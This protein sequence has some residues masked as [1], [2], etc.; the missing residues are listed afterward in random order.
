[1]ADVQVEVHLEEADARRALAEQTRAGLT[2]EQKSLP[3]VWFYDERGSQLFDDITRLPD[4]YP[5]RTERQILED[6]APAVV[7]H[8]GTDTLVEL[9]SGTSTKTRL[10]LDAM[11]DAECLDRFVPFDVSIEVLTAA[12]DDIAAA[13]AIAVRAVVGDFNRHLDRIPRR[14]RRLIAF[15]GGTIGNLDPGERSSFLADLAATLGPID[16]FLLGCDLVKDP[17]RLVAAYD[18]AGGVTAAFNRNAL[19]HVNRVLGADFDAAA[20]EHVALWNEEERWIEMR[21]RAARAQ[22]VR[23]QALDLELRFEEGEDLLTEI[24]AKFTPD[25]IEEELAAA[26]LEVHKQWTDADGDFMLTLAR[27]AR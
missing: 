11:R 14:G 24:S 21:L 12:A 7:W 10:L 4:Y 25:Q 9:G 6:H 26:G 20:F 19:D 18:D 1:M 2:A 15:L 22:T 16:R 5:T 27:P 8:A 3:P 13:Y 17:A 23:V